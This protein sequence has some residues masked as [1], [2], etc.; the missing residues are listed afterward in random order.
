MST[1]KNV[2]IVIPAYN[3]ENSIA[4]V[5]R[6]IIDDFPEF[7]YVVVNDGSKDGTEDVC[8]K[9]GFN[10]LDLRVNLGLSAAFQAGARYAFEAGYE[11]LIQIDGDG[12]HQPQYIKGMVDYAR[13]EN[14]D[15]VIGSRYIKDKK[16]NSLRMAGSCII[17]WL[18]YI[19]THKKICDPTSGMRLYSKRV[20]RAL[21]TNNDLRPE[22]DSIAWLIK[23]GAKVAEY[24]VVMLERQDGES[25]LSFTKSVKYM[26][27][28][29]FSIL[30][31][32]QFRG[33]EML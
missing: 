15:I 11:Y 31:I 23:S 13:N 27:R 16:K 28:M 17:E 24:P 29:C 30:I 7:D 25:Y 2:L 6:G 26:W 20:I 33:K 1:V 21:A 18:M 9:N 3:E 22:P 4:R 32:Q 5:V 10:L 12:Q 19:T 8:R 14:A